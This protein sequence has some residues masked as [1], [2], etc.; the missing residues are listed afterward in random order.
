MRL[1]LLLSGIACTGT[2]IAVNPP[3]G[4]PSVPPTT[5][6]AVTDTIV[7]VTTPAADI[8]FVVDPGA[9]QA[10]V[11]LADN[12]PFFLGYFLDSG[13]D[14]RIGVTSTLA[15]DA[16]GAV[17][18]G[19]G[20][21]LAT[22]PGYRLIDDETPNPGQVYTGLVGSLPTA[23]K[24]ANT[25]L[26]TTLAAWGAKD[27]LRRTDATLHTLV[28]SDTDDASLTTVAEF[29]AA[30]DSLATDASFVPIVPKTS[31]RY[32]DAAAQLGSDAVSPS[33]VGGEWR[34]VLDQLGL[35]ASG[36]RQEFFLSGTPVDGTLRVTVEQPIEGAG[37]ETNV[38]EFEP[39][40]YDSMGEIVNANPAETYEYVR[41][42]NSIV[43]LQFV[44]E[45]LS[46][47]VLRYD[48]D[49]EGAR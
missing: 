5:S 43:F 37:G 17:V 1:M 31:V 13:I 12:A 24:V 10:V 44:P 48:R 20:G 41:S 22:I 34:A 27:G 25:G 38:I 11:D 14:Y 49:G 16:D 36:L 19:T 6:D 23:P 35:V 32:L 29:V 39:V 4:E 47:V 33:P 46:R 30:Y 28:V 26:E 7:Q 2:T 45:A 15:T 9:T 21:L 8:L 18:D 3:I 42:S 40:E